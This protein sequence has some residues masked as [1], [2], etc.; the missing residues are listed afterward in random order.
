MTEDDIYHYAH[1][2]LV[3]HNNYGNYRVKNIK[4]H[5]IRKSNTGIS[6][7]KYSVNYSVEVYKPLDDNF[8]PINGKWITGDMEIDASDLDVKRDIILNSLLKGNPD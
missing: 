7:N 6:D 3:N 1:E 5:Q 2:L 4:I 8:I